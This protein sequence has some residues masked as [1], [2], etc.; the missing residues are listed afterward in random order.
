MSNPIQVPT[1]HAT[2]IINAYAK[3]ATFYLINLAL[4][5][6]T[7]IF[8][9]LYHSFCFASHSASL[10]SNNP[11]HGKMSIVCSLFTFSDARNLEH[12]W[13]LLHIW[14]IEKMGKKIKRSSMDKRN[15]SGS[16]STSRL[17]CVPFKLELM[18]WHWMH[19]ERLPPIKNN[20]FLYVVY[21]HLRVTMPPNAP[22]FNN[23]ISV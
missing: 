14:M 22:D 23:Q 20:R 7:L 19:N 5:Q 9:Y 8:L 12:K 11:A 21:T 4:S 15:T 17:I 16:W 6:I 10:D 2:A 1:L 13:T 3:K 18:W